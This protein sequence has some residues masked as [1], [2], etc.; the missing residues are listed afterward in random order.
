MKLFKT[1]S[2]TGTWW[3]RTSVSEESLR[4]PSLALVSIKRRI[5]LPL[6]NKWLITVLRARSAPRLL[7][8]RGIS[9]Q[10]SGAKV[11]IILFS[12]VIPSRCQTWSTMMSTEKGTPHPIPYTQTHTHAVPRKKLWP[13]GALSSSLRSASYI[14]KDCWERISARIPSPLSPFSPSPWLWI[15]FSHSTGTWIT[16][17]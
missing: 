8:T 2:L 17:N 13:A 12:G 10:D 9:E 14:S 4:A 15:G 5:F 16:D 1:R 7:E 11:S 3:V 6:Q